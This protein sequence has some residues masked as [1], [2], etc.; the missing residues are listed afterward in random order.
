MFSFVIIG[1]ISSIH[2]IHASL[3]KV[4]IILPLLLF[5]FTFKIIMHIFLIYVIH[6]F[7][8]D[9]Y[10]ILGHG[11]LGWQGWLSCPTQRVIFGAGRMHT[12]TCTGHGSSHGSLLRLST[13]SSSIV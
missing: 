9:F 13:L 10:W 4:L 3:T 1:S 12:P 6:R 5:F 7:H 2:S 8:F 11:S